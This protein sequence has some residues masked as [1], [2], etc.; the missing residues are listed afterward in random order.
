MILQEAG[1]GQRQRAAQRAAA[2][3]GRPTGDITAILRRIAKTVHTPG[4]Q[5]P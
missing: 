2:P 5:Y 4:S 3:H 1:A